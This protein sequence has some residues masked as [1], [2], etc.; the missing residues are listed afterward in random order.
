[1]PL[2]TE[3]RYWA[4]FY[5]PLVT[6][7]RYWALFY[8]SLYTFMHNLLNVLEQIADK[9]GLQEMFEGVGVLLAADSQST[10]SSGY[11]PSLWDPWPHFILLFFLRLTNTWF[12]FLRRPLWREDGSVIY[13][14]LTGPNN[15]TLLSHLRLCSLFVASYDAQGLRWKCSKDYGIYI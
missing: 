6:E 5:M 4:L 2:V 10:S 7:E 11:R 13:S 9:M 8:M 3:E 14:A 12:F 15:Y 1:M